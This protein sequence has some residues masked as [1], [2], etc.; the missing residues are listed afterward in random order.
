MSV[1]TELELRA[2]ISNATAGVSVVIALEGNIQLTGTPLVISANKHITLTSNGDDEFKLIGA[3]STDTITVSD[4]GVLELAGIIIT[5]VS[6]T[7]GRGVN[8]SSG[9]TLT[10]SNG[11]ISGNTS[12]NGGG[13]YNNAGSFTM[14]GGTISNNT[15]NT[16]GGGVCNFGG[17]FTMSGGTIS[18]NT[19]NAG[20]GVY[21]NA[22]SFTMLT[23]TISSNTANNGGGI[24]NNG[25]FT[26]LN[27]T[28]S[29]N[30]A[31]S[32]GGGIYLSNG[33]VELSGGT[34]S[35]N[36]ASYDGG[37]IWVAL[38]N[39]DKLYINSNVVFS[40]NR[41]ISACNRAAAQ[42]PVYNTNI[43]SNVTWTAPFTQGYNNYDISNPNGAPLKYN[44]TVNDSSAA[45]LS[46]AGSYIQNAKVTINAGTRPGYTFTGWT[47]NE[48]G[49]ILPN[50][51]TVS[52]DM[53]AKDV[54]VTVNWK[55][56]DKYN[57]TVHDGDGQFSGT[58]SY[59][60]GLS[61]TIV[62]G[63][64]PGYTFVGWTVNEGGIVLPNTPTA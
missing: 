45:E 7:L 32:E 54:A 38:E 25:S 10:M 61:A 47:T 57:V 26:M 49:F 46:G 62:A 63:S 12:A 42:D 6:G 41:A 3:S 34:L 1:S 60:E 15:A 4:G 50:I 44:V 64:R 20:G 14:S 58:G 48:S 28:I 16:F 35:G 39:L 19:A 2:A 18:N 9:G 31:T 24:Y 43:A 21:N 5:H 8:V 33:S 23:G 22:G 51:S 13:V 36:T 40:N 53:P 29:N 27:G 52:F 55:I 11:K 30:T 37:G 59:I 56:N 17:S